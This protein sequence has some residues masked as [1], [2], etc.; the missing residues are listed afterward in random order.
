MNQGSKNIFKARL[1]H[2]L[3]GDQKEIVSLVPVVD[4]AKEIR[5]KVQE[6]GNCGCI[7]WGAGNWSKWI[8]D[9]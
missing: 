8:R 5:Q 2:S 6:L 3:T 9:N 4:Y 7:L 1:L